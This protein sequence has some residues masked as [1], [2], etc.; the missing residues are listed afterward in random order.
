MSRFFYIS[1]LDG[2][3]QQLT[4]LG[5]DTGLRHVVANPLW[6]LA[7]PKVCIELPEAEILFLIEARWE[8]IRSIHLLPPAERLLQR[9]WPNCSLTYPPPVLASPSRPAG[10]AAP[11]GGARRRP[12]YKAEP[13]SEPQSVF[14]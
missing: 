6:L 13:V 10:V 9:S 3:K 11:G 2:K 12:Q 5:D 8:T 14:A 7:G 4:T 1:A